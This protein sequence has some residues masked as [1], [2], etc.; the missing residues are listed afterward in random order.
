MSDNAEVQTRANLLATGARAAET[1]ARSVAEK[2]GDM[3][4]ETNV[5]SLRGLSGDRRAGGGD[6]TL[7]RGR[8]H[9][10]QRGRHEDLGDA[11]PA[12]CG[13]AARTAD[14]GGAARHRAH[15]ERGGRRGDGH[16]GRLAGNG[17]RAGRGRAT[18]P[19]RR[20]GPLRV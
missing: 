14:G 4:I 16:A 2:P 11:R 3:P 15:R 18:R 5:A 7:R 12:R 6:R 19:R 17:A 8:L 10:A 1:L 9:G 13:H 20:P